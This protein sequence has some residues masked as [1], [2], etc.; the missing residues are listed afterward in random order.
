M[1]MMIGATKTMIR[2]TV[3]H[4]H[5]NLGFYFCA[6]IYGM[7]NTFTSLSRPTELG[8]LLTPLLFFI[9]SGF[10]EEIEMNTCQAL[11]LDVSVGMACF[12]LSTK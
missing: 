5:F 3:L 2:C 10:W 6:Y 9:C 12:D 4:P 11:S 8:M 7:I 1:M